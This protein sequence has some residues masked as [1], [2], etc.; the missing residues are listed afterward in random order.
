MGSHLLR[1]EQRAATA[2]RAAPHKTAGGD[3]RHL[4]ARQHPEP[5]EPLP[6]HRQLLL[7]RRA[8]DR[9]HE[10]RQNGGEVPQEQGRRHQPSDQHAER[11]LRRHNRG[12]RVLWRRRAAVHQRRVPVRVEVGTDGGHTRDH[13][14]RH[15][16]FDLH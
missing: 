9:H 4:P 3:P 2:T 6:Q 10:L 1:R 12:G 13:T 11:L 15:C 14:Q 5:A 16:L 7:R 8:P